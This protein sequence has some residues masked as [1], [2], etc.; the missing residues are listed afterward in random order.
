MLTP[1]VEFYSDSRAL[2]KDCKKPSKDEFWQVGRVTV[3][4]FVALGVVG[5]AIKLL[6]IPVNQLL[7][8]A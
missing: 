7:T 2:L 6:H 4:G 5:Y 1:L 3:L 8:T